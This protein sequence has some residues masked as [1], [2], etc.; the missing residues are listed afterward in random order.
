MAGI[1]A[2]RGDDE[3]RYGYSPDGRPVRRESEGDPRVLRRQLNTILRKGGEI[4][5]IVL[6]QKKN[7]A[8]IEGTNG[9]EGGPTDIDTVRQVESG[10]KRIMEIFGS[11]PILNAG[12]RLDKDQIGEVNGIIDQIIATIERL[13]HAAEGLEK[14]LNALGKLLD[15][16]DVI[17]GGGSNLAG[18]FGEARKRASAK[19]EIEAIQAKLRRV[20]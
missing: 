20:A 4:Y 17:T 10:V 5:D 14:L 11:S 7:P 19:D 9:K 12:Q 3:I 16:I 1:V 13:G 15:A 18:K 8:P 2:P 6:E